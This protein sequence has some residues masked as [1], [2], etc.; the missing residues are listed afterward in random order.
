MR[1]IEASLRKSDWGEHVSLARELRTWFR[2]SQE[3]NAYKLTVDDYVTSRDYISAFMSR[4]TP[5]RRQQV[6]QQ[7]ATADDAFQ[8]ATVADSDERLDRYF[9]IKRGDPW[10]W[11]RRPS[12]GPLAG[13]L[14]SN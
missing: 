10:W 3:V 9:R 2:L 8:G 14:A 7:V 6:E 1:R 12:S 13:Y 4:A 5:E 11:H